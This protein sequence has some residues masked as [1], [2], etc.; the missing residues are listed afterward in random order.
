MN[1]RVLGLGFLT[2]F[3]IGWWSWIE[4]PSAPKLREAAVSAV[5]QT[6]ATPDVPVSE[7]Q[8]EAIPRSPASLTPKNEK[9]FEYQRELDIFASLKNKVFLTEQ[10][11]DE[12]ARMLRDTSLLRALGLRLTETSLTTTVMAS[13][14]L[15]V[16]LLVEALKAGDAVMASE[17]AKIVIED[18]Q[19]ENSSLE[20]SVREH[21]AGIKAEVLYHWAA[22]LPDE[23]A[24]VE[25]SLPGPVSQK[26]W[27]NV[28]REHASNHA[29]STEELA[30]RK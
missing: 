27:A 12:R 26:I 7:G 25:R 22:Y 23:A 28:A 30:K 19:V 8:V 24:R 14:D 15:A 13:Q 18:A 11:T 17:V 20:R 21:L 16:D 6:P 9:P 2:M 4:T 5:E 10:E 3:V 1:S 29:E